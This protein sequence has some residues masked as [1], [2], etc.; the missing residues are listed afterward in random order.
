MDVMIFGSMSM[1]KE[2][3]EIFFFKSLGFVWRRRFMK[4]YFFIC[5]GLMFLV[6]CVCTQG[7]VAA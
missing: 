3:E 4:V 6:F 2:M 7:I 5:L 1:S